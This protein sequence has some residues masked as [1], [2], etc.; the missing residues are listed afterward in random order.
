MTLGIPKPIGMA[1]QFV[2]DLMKPLQRKVAYKQIDKHPIASTEQGQF[3]AARFIANVITSDPEDA[4]EGQRCH[5]ILAGH[6]GSSGSGKQ[7][8]QMD[9][10]FWLPDCA[11]LQEDQTS[12]DQD[13]FV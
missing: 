5:G 4:T 2:E 6:H 7:S 13:L 3:E 10:A 1:A 8:G 12:R 11:R 9:I